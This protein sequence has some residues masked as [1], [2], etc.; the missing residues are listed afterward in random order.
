MTDEQPCNTARLMRYVGFSLMA[1][2]LAHILSCA[3]AIILGCGEAFDVPAVVL[4]FLGRA[5]SKGSRRA[6]KWALGFS[7]WYVAIMI[8]LAA[9]A[10]WMPE[11]LAAMS[12]GRIGVDEARLFVLHVPA[13]LV[14]SLFNALMLG[15]LLRK[16]PVRRTAAEALK[17]IRAG[18]S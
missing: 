9:L 13:A 6:G 16:T 17:K 1:F 18:G 4:F 7:I 5:V 8:L 14:W 15:G 11:S 10:V 12:R 3:V 2:S